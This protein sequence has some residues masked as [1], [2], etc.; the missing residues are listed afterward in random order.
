MVPTK[1]KMVSV[2]GIVIKDA[3]CAIEAYIDLIKRR[4][5]SLEIEHFCEGV[6]QKCEYI[7]EDVIG[8]I[9]HEEETIMHA[10]LT[11]RYKFSRRSKDRLYTCDSD[12]QQVFF[13]VVRQFDCTILGGYRD[14]EVQNALYAN[15]KSKLR[16]PD[17][18]HNTDPSE[19]VDVA[20][21]PIDW[22]DLDRFRFFAGYVIGVAHSMG[23]QLRW[24]GDWDSDTQ[25]KDNKFNDLVHFETVKGG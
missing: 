5:P 22:E 21:H 23:I 16:W 25:V 2:D 10:P 8:P 4:E 13:Q 15:G 11:P 20:P 6:L 24:G 18:K 1:T 9:E 7:K 17:S 12:L 19:G 3:V 14:K